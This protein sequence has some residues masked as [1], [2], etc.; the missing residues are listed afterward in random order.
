MIEKEDVEVIIWRVHNEI[1]FP[2]H[3]DATASDSHAK[4]AQYFASRI[5]LAPEHC[6]PDFLRVYVKIKGWPVVSDH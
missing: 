1:T 2:S 3:C 5:Q 4:S 6:Y